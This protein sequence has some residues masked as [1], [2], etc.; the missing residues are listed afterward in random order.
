VVIYLFSYCM[1]CVSNGL[2]HRIVFVFFCFFLG[3]DC[4]LH[5]RRSP[6][7]PETC[8]RDTEYHSLF[9]CGN[10]EPDLVFRQ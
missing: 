3:I 10:L 6:T 5:D 4:A 7:T 2:A 1:M 9:A 8:R